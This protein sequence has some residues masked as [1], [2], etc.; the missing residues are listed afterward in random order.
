MNEDRM[1]KRAWA[2]G[3]GALG[4]IA[5]L[6]IG[7]AVL[8]FG[9]GPGAAIA[10]EIELPE[11]LSALSSSPQIPAHDIS[12]E[13]VALL[14]QTKAREEALIQKEE[15]FEARVQALALIEE[16]VARDIARLEAAEAELRSTISVA[17]GAAESDINSLT[18]VYENMKPERA[19]PLF[20][21]MEPSFAAGFLGRMRADAAA[22]IMA[23]LEPDLAY[24]ISV[25]LAGRNA[26]VERS[27]SNTET[28]I[29]KQ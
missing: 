5:L 19:A 22:A 28:E 6:L 4:F 10:K 1:P 25:V 3:R 20:Q 15:A 18:M 12:P 27:A 14:T 21:R 29:Q 8:R 9:V 13:L 17:D 16:A 24:S 26:D 23:N 2:S 11:T 7:S